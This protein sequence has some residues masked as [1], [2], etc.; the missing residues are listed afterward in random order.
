MAIIV[1]KYGGSSLSDAV[2]I[3]DV[4]KRI[5]KASDNSN[6]IVVVVSAMGNTTGR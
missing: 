2:K 1:Q 6:Q 4:A 5:G 3:I